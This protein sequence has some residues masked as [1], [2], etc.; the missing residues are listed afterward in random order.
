M[1][2][3]GGA[4]TDTVTA[5]FLTVP[6]P[7]GGAGG[8]TLTSRETIAPSACAD[9]F[10]SGSTGGASGFTTPSFFDIG[11]LQNS[12][13]ILP[14]LLLAILLFQPPFPFLTV[15]D[16]TL[17]D[18]LGGRRLVLPMPLVVP[19]AVPRGLGRPDV[20][21]VDGF[22]IEHRGAGIHLDPKAYQFLL[23]H[24]EAAPAHLGIVLQFLQRRLAHHAFPGGILH[25]SSKVENFTQNGPAEIWRSLTSA[26]S[27]SRSTRSTRHP[28]P[29]GFLA[30]V[31]SWKRPWILL[32]SIMPSS[33][34]L[35][36]PDP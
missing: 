16:D 4:S 25:F 14:R 9:W 35:P 31:C 33:P 17:V 2:T 26:L 23:D 11:S 12:F 24:V 8:W 3:G 10:L 5:S 36:G 22:R 30:I 32:F 20:E 18:A 29:A 34:V 15:P 28:R 6:R 27:F 21:V 13:R 1:G 7:G 19:L